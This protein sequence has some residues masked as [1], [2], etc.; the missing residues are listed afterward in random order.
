MTAAV[1]EQETTAEELPRRRR[2]RETYEDTF[3][4]RRSTA[5]H[6]TAQLDDDGDAEAVATDE[7]MK[8][9]RQPTMTSTKT[10]TTTDTTPFGTAGHASTA[11]PTVTT[12]M[13]TTKA[14]RLCTS[15][16]EDVKRTGLR[17]L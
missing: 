8:L 10:P 5:Q 11:L 15:V 12:L 1:C 6:S 16:R 9:P 4:E 13:M 17:L 7:D 3:A 14:E 2:R